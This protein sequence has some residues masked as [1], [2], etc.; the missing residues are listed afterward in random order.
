M[1]TVIHLRNKSDARFNSTGLF[2]FPL[3]VNVGFLAATHLHLLDQP[4]E[5]SALR[6]LEIRM[7]AS[8]IPRSLA[9]PSAS[10]VSGILHQRTGPPTGPRP[11][12]CLVPQGREPGRTCRYHRTRPHVRP[13]LWRASG[14]SKGHGMAAPRR[15]RRIRPRTDGCWAALFSGIRC[16]V[17]L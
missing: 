2:S 8:C 15:R 10:L 13:R 4:R 16:C 17:G 14:L 6:I 9:Q 1:A 3:H 11:S 7:R 5:L 12:A